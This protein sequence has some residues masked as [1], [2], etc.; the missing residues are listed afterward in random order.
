MMS[1]ILDE[2]FGY[3]SSTVTGKGIQDAV[4]HDGEE[5]YLE[6]SYEDSNVFST[7]HSVTAITLLIPGFPVFVKLGTNFGCRSL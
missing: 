6:S 5:M 4:N 2:N 3:V 1:V 7:S